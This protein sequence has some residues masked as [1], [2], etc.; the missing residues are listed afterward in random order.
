MKTSALKIGLSYIYNKQLIHEK[1]KEKKKVIVKEH[2]RLPA[3]VAH[4]IYSVES[5]LDHKIFP[6]TQNNI[7]LE[8]L[9]KLMIYD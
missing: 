2:K 3:K 4:I 5:T 6:G 8:I 1:K 7:T 9:S